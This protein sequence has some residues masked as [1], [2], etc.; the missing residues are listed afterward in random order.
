MTGVH[1]TPSERFW[2]KVSKG[3]EREC[4][5]WK[6]AQISKGYGVFSNGSGSTLA[7]RF[8]YTE[9][10]GPIPDELVIDHLCRNPNC[11]N[12]W[13]MEIVT[14]AENVRRGRAGA[15]NRE[16]THCKHGHE[17]TA[18]NTYTY[19]Q[20]GKRRC[21]TCAKRWT[22]EFRVREKERPPTRSST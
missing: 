11:V 3:T 9:L 17:F 19:V 5:A 10:R 1:G 18:E 21:K 12:P 6:G 7:H 15:K 22:K 2:P 14:F 13:H 8:S 4:W 16:K 20:S